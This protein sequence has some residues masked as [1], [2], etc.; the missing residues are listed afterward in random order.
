MNVY[1][2]HADRRIRELHERMLAYRR[3]KRMIKLKK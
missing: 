3:K 2:N 1:E